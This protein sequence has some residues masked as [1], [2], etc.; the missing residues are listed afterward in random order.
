MQEGTLLEPF[1]RAPA[2]LRQQARVVAHAAEYA[3]GDRGLHDPRVVL[4]AAALGREA[5]V[6]T[7]DAG[8]PA[9]RALGRDGAPRT[10]HP[11]DP[12]SYTHLRAHETRHDLVC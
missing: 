1:A 10:P 8:L 3:E 12:V 7:L 6:R 2:G 5:D 4:D 9:E 11:R